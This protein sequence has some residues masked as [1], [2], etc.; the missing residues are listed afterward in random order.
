MD[1]Y[2]ILGVDY[3]EAQDK[4][5]LRP[6]R[7]YNREER[8]IGS[9]L[10][11]VMA[12]LIITAVLF[13]RSAFYKVGPEISPKHY[14]EEVYRGKTNSGSEMH[15]LQINYVIRNS[16]TGYS[17]SGCDTSI[18]LDKY[19]NIRKSDRAKYEIFKSGY[20][21]IEREWLVILKWIVLILG[22][23]LYLLGLLMAEGPP[24]IEFTDFMI[25]VL[26][27]RFSRRSSKFKK[28]FGYNNSD[29]E[30]K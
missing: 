3:R 12:F 16:E 21:P 11:F 5:F 1:D 20:L 26:Q 8:L 22:G 18:R 17:Y 29:S 4:C 23:L 9:I 6:A 2:T 27:I 19:G 13:P 30:Y 24:V 7:K 15:Y 14:S 10:G 28:F 25:C